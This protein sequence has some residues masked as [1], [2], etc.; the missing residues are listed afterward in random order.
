MKRFADGLDIGWSIRCFSSGRETFS[1]AAHWPPAQ[2][3]TTQKAGPTSL[4]QTSFDG[5]MAENI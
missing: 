5:T 2:D 1:R 4:G 3:G